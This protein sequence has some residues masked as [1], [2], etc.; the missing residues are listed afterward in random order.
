MAI[1]GHTYGTS[2]LSAAGF[3]NILSDPSTPY[4]ALDLADVAVLRPDLVLAPSEPYPFAE[5]H[6]QVLEEVGPVEFVDGRDLFWWG[7]RTVAALGRLRN[8]AATVHPG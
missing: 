5:R 8:L 1:G 6:R 7:V 4:P 3:D 2:I